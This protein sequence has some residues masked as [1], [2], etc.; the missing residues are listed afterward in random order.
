MNIKSRVRRLS[1]RYQTRQQLRCLP[2]HLLKDIG[3]TRQD[4]TKELN[5]NTLIGVIARFLQPVRKGA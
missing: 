5:K 2:D 4:V 1:S 3:K